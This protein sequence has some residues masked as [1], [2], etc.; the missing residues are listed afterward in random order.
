MEKLKK[1]FPSSNIRTFIAPYDEISKE[2]FDI[3]TKRKYNLCINTNFV[4]NV[5]LKSFKY[6]FLFFRQNKFNYSRLQQVYCFDRSLVFL[7]DN[8]FDKQNL[9]AFSDKG[10]HYLLVALPDKVPVYG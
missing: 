5:A 9:I 4:F 3:L 2:T 7:S 8:C 10:I 6:S 1:A